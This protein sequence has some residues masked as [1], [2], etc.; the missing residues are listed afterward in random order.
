MD[1]GSTKAAR[2]VEDWVG[3]VVVVVVVVVVLVDCRTNGEGSK[4]FDNKW[5]VVEAPPM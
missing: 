5:F 4:G 3:L 1:D 2:A